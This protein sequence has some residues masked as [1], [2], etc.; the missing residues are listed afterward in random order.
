MNA[1]ERAERIYTLFQP[2]S[3]MRYLNRVTLVPM[4]EETILAAEQAARADER[5]KTLEEC[6]AVAR[7]KMICG[8]GRRDCKTDRIPERIAEDIRALAGKKEGA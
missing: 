4:I 7:S 1:R 8:C 6:E 3:T 5:R 2:D